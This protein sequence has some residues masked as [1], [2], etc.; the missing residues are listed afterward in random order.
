MTGYSSFPT[1]PYGALLAETPYP[2]AI[3]HRELPDGRVIVIYPQIFTTRLCIGPAKGQTYDDAWCYHHPDV[4]LVAASQWD[5][6]NDPP[7]G[8]H[9]H[10][11]TGRRRP[12][13][14]PTREYIQR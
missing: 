5:G 1:P 7:D 14:D 4:A 10:I 8:W 13:G 3:Y 12:H 11:G 9:R 2:G 6:Q